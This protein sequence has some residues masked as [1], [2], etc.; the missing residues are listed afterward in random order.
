V[1]AERW[2][3]A[4]VVLFTVARHELGRKSEAISFV[5]LSGISYGINWL[6]L[7]PYLANLV[8]QNITFC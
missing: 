4:A 5:L 6:I 7:R 3:G 1:V 2:A 8:S